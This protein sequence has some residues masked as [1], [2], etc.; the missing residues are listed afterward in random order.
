MSIVE[1]NFS[2]MG[3]RREQPLFG[4]YSHLSEIRPWICPV[5]MANLVWYVAVA[6]CFLRR[7][8]APESE[9]LGQHNI[10]VNHGRCIRDPIPDRGLMK[11]AI[12]EVPW[13]EIHSAIET[14]IIVLNGF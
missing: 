1:I 2:L 9:E 11:M 10:S 4:N 12:P 13:G 8:T 7:A 5:L 14:T 3:R 6:K